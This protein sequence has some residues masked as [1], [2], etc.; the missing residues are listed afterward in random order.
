MDK[1][2]KAKKEL[3][4]HIRDNALR[5][6]GPFELASGGTSNWYLDGRQVTYSG[7]G[8]R[9]VAACI[10]ELLNPE[11]SAI[12]GLTMGADPVAIATAL[13][14][15]PPMRSFS[16]RKTEKSH[17]A[18]GRMV[19]PLAT[20]DRVAVVDDTTTT[21]SS[22][23]ESITVLQEAGIDVVQALVV[24]DRSNGEAGRRCAEL[25]VPFTAVILPAD[26]GIV[27]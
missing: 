3:V 2:S 24:V 15:E 26:L 5:T 20:T 18:G 25:G 7:V 11:V 10:G 16:I 22:F 4:T 1:F 23:V 9:L 8:G 13:L 14:A 12:G 27:E 6:D 21:G 19:G 17:G